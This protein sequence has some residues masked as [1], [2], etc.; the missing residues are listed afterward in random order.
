MERNGKKYK[1]AQLVM[2][3]WFFSRE[4]IPADRV[5]LED[6]SKGKQLHSKTKLFE[7]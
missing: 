4:E 2:A 7:D 6:T 5:T 3:H 1:T